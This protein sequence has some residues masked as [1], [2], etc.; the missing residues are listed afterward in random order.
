MTPQVIARK[1]SEILEET[2]THVE[3]A[4]RV[5]KLIVEIHSL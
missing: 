5:A 1:L 3:L 2:D 4:N